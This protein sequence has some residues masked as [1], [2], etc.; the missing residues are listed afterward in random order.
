M[1][2]EAD[3]VAVLTS[4]E[5]DLNST[6][7]LSD[8]K[9]ILTFDQDISNCWVV[10]DYTITLD[11]GAGNTYGTADVTFGTGDFT[12]ADGS[13]NTV[14]IDFTSQGQALYEN[15][16]D[17]IFGIEVTN[18]SNLTPQIDASNK[19]TDADIPNRE[20][21][22]LDLKVNSETIEGFSYDHY[23]YEAYLKYDDYTNSDGV[24][25][26]YV[27][28]IPKDT[29][30]SFVQSNSG[31]VHTVT[32]TA[33]DGLTTNEYVI[34]FNLDYYEIDGFLDGV[35]I[36]DPGHE[37]DSS[38]ET[39]T[40]TK[41]LSSGT[42]TVP[43]LT[44]TASHPDATVDISG[45]GSLPGTYTYT[46]VVSVTDVGTKT[47][48]LILKASSGSSGS[49]NDDDDNNSNSS[50]DQTENNSTVSDI[51]DVVDTTDSTTVVDDLSALVE[52]TSGQLDDITTEEDVETA[53]NNSVQTLEIIKDI[54]PTETDQEEIETLIQKDVENLEQV[55]EKTEDPNVKTEAVT[56]YLANLD[57]VHTETELE[58]T[59]ELDNTVED[60]VERVVEAI[61]E[62]EMEKE[63]E[64]TDEKASMDVDTE[65]ITKQV[66]SALEQVK[67]LK[68]PTMII[69][70]TAVSV[71]LKRQ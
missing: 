14:E 12:V 56:D 53:I 29:Y 10:S 23:E 49:S 3:G 69:L 62:V 2:Q 44:I 33:E 11:D 51:E 39:N 7:D 4:A 67:N 30:A 64:V 19:S 32:V 59:A 27:T 26:T 9:L 66:E 13:G 18:Y 65:D 46:I 28:P 17:A 60:L 70:K 24:F 34:T 41:T 16:T 6:S 55:L 43:E 54:D 71:R 15:S 37:M 21:R 31:D 68:M 42:S 40:L 52:D 58:H 38:N 63:F 25:D 61:G 35:K 22:L 45:S 36:E 47:Y 1:I 57:E 20:S 50:S 5:Y 8:D 48:T